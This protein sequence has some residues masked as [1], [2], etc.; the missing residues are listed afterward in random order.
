MEFTDRVAVV[1]GGGAGIGRKLVNQLA[2]AG[3]STAEQVRAA[4][5][6]LRD[7]AQTTV[8]EAPTMILAALRR[9]EQR[10]LVG[11]DAYQVNALV[12]ADPDGVY[13]TGVGV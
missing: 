6:A 11:E 8:P 5:A 7:A 13:D 9:G 12:R 1:T 10:I 4:S 3:C 2:Q